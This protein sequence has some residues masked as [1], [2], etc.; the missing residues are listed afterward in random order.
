MQNFTEKENQINLGEKLDS[1]D[2]IRE[3]AHMSEMTVK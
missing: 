1:V 2:K 3:K